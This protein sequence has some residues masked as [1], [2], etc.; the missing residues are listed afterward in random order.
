IPDA[1][2]AGLHQ[3]G[4]DFVRIWLLRRTPKIQSITAKTIATNFESAERLL[5]RL[6]KRTANRHRLADA[7]HLRG[8]RGVGI[9][10]FLEREP[11]HLGDHVIDRRLETG[12]RFASD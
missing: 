6:L 10:K 9:G 12:G 3:S 7:L 1:L 5:K 4:R 2:G 8:E 11:W